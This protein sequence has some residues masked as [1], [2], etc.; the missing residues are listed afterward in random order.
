MRYVLATFAVALGIIATAA[1]PA[2]A[3]PPAG[4]NVTAA[5]F[6]R[7]QEGPYYD[8]SGNPSWRPLDVPVNLLDESG[9]VV[10]TA[11]PN[12]YGEFRFAHV[13]PGTYTVSF[14]YPSLF[15]PIYQDRTYTRVLTWSN[16]RDSYEL[17]VDINPYTNTPSYD[18]LNVHT[19]CPQPVPAGRGCNR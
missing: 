17:L 2:L 11:D 15:D 19:R 4:G 12:P 5:L 3:D 8:V 18:V 9:R 7:I 1:T 13:S 6:G 10:A 16:A 14:T